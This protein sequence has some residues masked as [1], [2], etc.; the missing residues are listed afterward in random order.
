M[1]ELEWVESLE[2]DLRDDGPDARANRLYQFVRQCRQRVEQEVQ[3]HKA[4]M[5]EYRR[6]WPQ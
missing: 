5:A 2:A 6:R 1:T 4:K 3:D